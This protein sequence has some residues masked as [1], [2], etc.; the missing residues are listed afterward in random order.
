MANIPNQNDVNAIV[1][2]IVSNTEASN[3][4]LDAVM[5]SIRKLVDTKKGLDNVKLSD[6][7]SVESM[8]V[9]YRNTIRNIINVLC[10]D[11][12][13]QSRDLHKLLGAIKDP[14]KS[15][16]NKVVLK[17]KTIDA[18]LQLPK[19]IDSMFGV[20][21][22]ISEQN[23][24]FKALLKFR[25]N[26]WKISPIINSLFK[27]LLAVFQSIDV[28]TPMDK[29][30]EMLVKQPDIIEQQMNV[31][32]DGEFSKSDASKTI[33]KQGKLGILDAFAKT[34]E[35]INTLNT[36]RV[37]SF[38]MLKL[39]L[40]N[41][42]I[43]LTWILDSIIG[44]AEKNIVDVKKRRA[45][46]AIETALIGKENKKGIREGGLQG[47]IQ[48]LVNV[49][50][51]TKKMKIN[52]GSLIMVMLSLK[53]LGSIIDII[54]GMQDKFSALA[55][56]T[57]GDNIHAASKTIDKVAAIFK[58]VCLLGLLAIPMILSGIILLSAIPM[59]MLIVILISGL[60]E[61][62]KKRKLDD[63][64]LEPL[65]TIFQSLKKIMVDILL[66]G[67]AAIPATV[68]MLMVATFTVGLLIFVGLMVLV[69][70]L[71][72]EISEEVVQSLKKVLLMLGALTMIMIAILLLALATPV[73]VD[74]LEG[75][76][77]P[78]CLL[79]TTSLGILYVLMKLA[80]KFA[81]KATGYAIT[82]GISMVLITG[83]LLLGAIALL[84]LATI[85][86]QM[87]GK[88]FGQIAI[89][90]GGIIAFL[91]VVVGL[92]I[93]LTA[94]AP[95][96][97]ISTAMF[98][99]V[100]ACIG[101]IAGVALAIFTLSNLKVNWGKYKK[102]GEIIGTGEG[103]IGNVGMTIDFVKYLSERLGD[104]GEKSQ[105]RKAKKALKPV[106]KIV[107]QLKEIVKSLNTIQEIELNTDKILERTQTIFAFIGDLQTKINDW[108]DPH[109]NEQ[110]AT[111]KGA[112]VKNMW[113]SI[114]TA[115]KNKAA[116]ERRAKEAAMAAVELDRVSKLITLLDN[117]VNALESI[118]NINLNQD[119]IIGNLE[120]IFAF[121][122]KLEEK[123]NVWINPN[124]S[125][126]TNVQLAYKT[127]HNNLQDARS[128]KKMTKVDAILS[129]I[130]NVTESIKTLKEIKLTDK[131]I[132][133][134]TTNVSVVFSTID[135]IHSIIE[136]NIDKLKGYKED[137]SLNTA[138]ET[139]TQI[140][141]VMKDIAEINNANLDKNIKS[142]EK[143]VASINN[144]DIERVSKTAD[145]FRQM[146]EFSNSIKGDFD[147]LAEALGDKLLPVLE[148]LKGVMTE[149]P[150]KLD[151]GFQNTS[152]SIGAAGTAAAGTT[153]G[154]KAQI[155][156]ENPNISDVDL[157]KQAQQRMSQQASLNAKGVE[158]K[159]AEI[160]SILKSHGVK[161]ID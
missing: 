121:I 125:N 22:T 150:Q 119:L 126:L 61:F 44:W 70:K 21:D 151:E 77:L 10:Q 5:G 31:Q 159:L 146:S 109:K 108:M 63:E 120:T 112:W 117:I 59:L 54:V 90:L 24:G 98:A 51:S 130:T 144:M 35:V 27:D 141:T 92:G 133:T 91:A 94:A 43:A 111:G 4:V 6:V 58:T 26:L 139:I 20:F 136:T 129:L 137:T 97:A 33:T 142:Y 40:H 96:I 19:V 46:R 45:L 106:N 93:A 89:M 47:I 13:G 7:E 131:D 12:N 15:T 29:I 138:T 140:A 128:Q 23:F 84:A 81:T 80:S 18:A 3:N 14:N 115:A 154:V 50:E 74:A 103:A 147:A 56:K 55:D 28:N 145:M 83:A 30:M 135:G 123:I 113:N 132:E 102:S 149:I 88:K 8:V 148:E 100:V 105:Y 143:F 124:N 69:S 101:V 38:T 118:Q 16:D 86:S 79:L 57:I 156:R 158:S 68:A 1:E 52:I 65:S 2:A 64:T 85:A 71:L 34:F 60:T 9:S 110:K 161:I 72:K 153:E 155:K 17:Y 104:I 41:M 36:L 62:L 75:I 152:A 66:V 107:N 114:K 99:P 157:N 48:A 42:Q 82:L 49:F 37:P 11:D 73:I 160:I 39:R 67:L 53:M 134:I 95:F 87:T 25:I 32:Q 76:I 122:G 78:F 127:M 116:R